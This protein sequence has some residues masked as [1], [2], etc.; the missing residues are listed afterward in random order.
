MLT[1]EF[2]AALRGSAGLVFRLGWSPTPRCG[3]G[4]ER[5]IGGPLQRGQQTPGVP[6]RPQQ[7]GSFDKSSELACRNQRNITRTPPPNDLRFLIVDNLV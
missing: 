2:E 4:A 6:R 1:L 5:R 7:V 3:E